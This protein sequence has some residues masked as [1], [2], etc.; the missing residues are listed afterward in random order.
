MT[1]FPVEGLGVG[2]LQT[3]RDP[4]DELAELAT[5]AGGLAHEVRNP[6]STLSVNLQ[7]LAEDW[8]GDIG[9][10]ETLRR[11]SLNRLAAVRKEAER[12]DRTLGDFLRLVTR[13]E[14]ASQDRD[15]NIVVAELVEF[16]G[17][18]AASK[19]IRM[20]TALY[21]D[22]LVCPVDAN[23]LKQAVLNVLL[24]AQEA[25]PNGGELMVRTRPDGPATVR[26]DITDTGVG[27][28]SEAVDRAFTAFSSSKKGGSGLGLALSRR[29]IRQ[30]GGTIQLESEPGKGTN[31]I[32]RLPRSGHE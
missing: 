15:L 5:L 32:I 20:R 27:M 25:M 14:L 22:A 9:D 11:R 3:G 17:P 24:N 7:L 1:T 31:V 4:A 12:L 30:H 18:Q 21:A 8:Q 28:S 6:L 13:N 23:L 16:F 29:I 26:L 19:S 10:I 2:E